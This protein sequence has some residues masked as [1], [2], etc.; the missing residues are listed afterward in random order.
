VFT[1]EMLAAQQGDAV[2]IEYGARNSVHRVL[3]DAGTPASADAIKQRI[4]RLPPDQRRFDLLVITHVDTDHIGGVLKL[5]AERPAGLAFDDVWFNAWRH[6]DRVESSRLGPIDG[7]ILSTTLDKLGWRWNAAFDARAVVVGAT[8]APPSK[9]LRGGMKLTVL[10]P[11]HQQ[12]ARLRSNWSSV[13]RAAGL[14]PRDPDR[15]ARL[16]ER[17]AKKG[18]SSS[19]LGGRLDVPTLGRSAFQSDKASANGSTVA[20]LAEFEGAKCV[21]SGDAFA[22]VIV[23]AIGRLL[24]ARRERRLSVDAFKLPHHGSRYNVSI[25][26]LNSVASP[27]YLFSTSGAIFGHPDDE[28]VARVLSADTRAAKTLHFNYPAATLRAN[29]AKIKKRDAP[30]WNQSR[31]LRQF[32]Y[33]THYATDDTAGLTLSLQR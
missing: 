32:R 30:D 13:V 15:W 14:D 11:G 6:I 1:I 31:L 21:L 24:E 18:V 5:L 33:Q 7:E 10:S 23:D 19:I 16:L 26:L 22:G 27:H 25:D 28:A 4:E 12:L 8:G 20:L 29:Y 2:W 3:I 17:A 9:Q